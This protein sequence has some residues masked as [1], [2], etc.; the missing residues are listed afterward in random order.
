MTS[1]KGLQWVVELRSGLPTGKINRNLPDA[2]PKSHTASRLKLEKRKTADVLDVPVLKKSSS[3][4]MHLA[5]HRIGVAAN[6]S[7]LRFE[8]GLRDY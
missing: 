1:E 5:R 6:S 3:E 4:F 2:A 7:Q 8:S